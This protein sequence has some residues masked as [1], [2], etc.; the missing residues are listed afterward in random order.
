MPKKTTILIIILAVVTGVLLFL[1]ITEGQKQSSPSTSI[2]PT[3]KVV[4]KT[5]KVFFSPQN[6]DLSAGS[7]TAAPTVDIMV[8]TGGSDIAGVQAELQYDP[9]VLAGVKLVPAADTTGFFGPGAVVLF[10]DVDNQTGRISFAIAIS[11]G[12]KSAKGVGKIGTLTFTKAF[13]ATSPTTSINFLDKTLVTQLGEN[14]SVL[15]Q[16]SPL[17]ITLTSTQ[18]VVTQFVPPATNTVPPTQ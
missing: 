7:A 6:I 12:Q 17:N 1:A 3:Q 11:A 8:D 18:P 5:A 13:G 14:E 10:N 9:K 15:K 16:A 2:A 4:Q